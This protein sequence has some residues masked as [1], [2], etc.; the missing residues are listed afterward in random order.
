[1]ILSDNLETNNI[2]G[3]A[4][5][6]LI[7]LIIYVENKVRNPPSFR[8]LII[9]T[10]NANYTQYDIMQLIKIKNDYPKINLVIYGGSG[11]PF[12]SFSQVVVCVISFI[13]LMVNLGCKRA[14]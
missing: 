10:K 5:K 12:V 11:A 9:N 4:S 6:G 13:L 2:Y 1:M 3:N 8:L 7:P 14:C